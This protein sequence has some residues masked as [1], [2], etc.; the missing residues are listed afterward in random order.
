MLVSDYYK[1]GV[2]QPSLEF[3]DVDVVM[4]IRVFVDPHAFRYINTDW[5]RE[6]V[7]LLQDFYDELT[8][9]IRAGNRMRGL[10]LL[11]HAG[12]SNEVHL[13]LSSAQ[14]QGSGIADGL[15]AQIYDALSGST[16]V[17]TG[18]AHDIEETVLFV[19]GILHDRISDMTI[20]IVR[21][22]LI[23]FTQAMCDKYGM[24]LVPGVD[25]GP[26]WDRHSHAWT[27]GLTPLP[28]PNETKLVLVPRA[29]VRK[30]GTF[31]PG[32]YLSNFVLDYMVDKELELPRSP[33]IQ[34]RSSTGKL[35]GRPYV[36]KKS[37]LERENK[38]TKAINSEMTNEEPRLLEDYRASRA[39][40]SEP[41]PHDVLAV[42]TGAPEPDW[43][44][45]LADVLL[46]PPGRAGADNYHRAVQNLLTALFYPALDLPEREFKTHNGRKRIDIKYANLAA[47]G[48][49]HYLWNA[50]GVEAASVVVECKNYA[51]GLT[52]VEFDQITGRFSP[53]RGRFGLLL[54]RG[55]ENEKASV[56][57]HCRDAA[58]DDRGY[59]IALDDDDLETLVKARKDGDGTVFTYLL[60][61]FRELI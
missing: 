53:R 30:R 44:R 48:F 3:L 15:A 12:E 10:A 41:P 61:R 5:A 29:I 34:H 57:Q 38:S 1:L 42:L 55:Y 28:M 11:A 6:C 47:N 13:G 8:A 2:T 18:L 33:L 16:A 45:L 52:N 58:L 59:V 27:S 4:D 39:G 46:V 25:S 35:Q 9:A 50:G 36:T 43:D 37:I 40:K 19:D 14:S 20:N 23:P 22:E 51:M 32:D 7:A 56:I 54:Y 21:S 60:K 17:A 31:D 26:M 24:A 49:F